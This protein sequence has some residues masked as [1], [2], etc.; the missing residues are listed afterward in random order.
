MG[1][2]SYAI[3]ILGDASMHNLSKNYTSTVHIP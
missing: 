3:R 2:L 1:G